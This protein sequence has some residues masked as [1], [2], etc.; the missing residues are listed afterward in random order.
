MENLPSHPPI[1]RIKEAAL[2][3]E[4][5]RARRHLD[6]FGLTMAGAVLM[7][8]LTN[9]WHLSPLPDSLKAFIMTM[10]VASL[11]FSGSW[12]INS[13]VWLPL[14]IHLL[15]RRRRASGR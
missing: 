10:C 13:M 6:V 3:I 14:R 7:L 8:L 2:I 4:Y 1:L 9:D 11:G 15:R 12:F 5:S